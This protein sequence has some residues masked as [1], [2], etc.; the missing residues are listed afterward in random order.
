MLDI[1][2]E[3]GRINYQ[4]CIEAMLPP[5]VEHCAAKKDPGEL[6]V[7]LAGLGKD[8]VPAACALLEQMSVDEKDKMVIWLIM[9]HEERL[10]NASNRH[11]AAFLGGELVRIGR[12]IALDQP[13]SRMTLLASQVE[14]DYAG[15]LDCPLVTE[16]VE[17]ISGDNGILKGAARMMLSMGRLMSP[18]AL[19]KQGLN[20]LGTQRIKEK[21]MHAIMEG[22]QQAGLDIELA[23]MTA[24]QSAGGQ[25]SQATDG[26][27]IPAD[28]EKKLMADMTAEVQKLRGAAR[29]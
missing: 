18:A 24:E 28:Y 21:L 19:E 3:I 1:R 16:G 5:L 8:A 29:A 23:D 14:I 9:S 15:L 26:T 25:M 12:L 4:R 2:L 22:L 11:L 17:N 10:R 13:G 20:L 7:F 6:D 27:V